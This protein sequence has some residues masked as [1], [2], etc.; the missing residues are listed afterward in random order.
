MRI[1]HYIPSIDRS[2]GGTSA[3]MQLLC[4]SLGRMAELH[5]ATHE[6]RE[7]LP[8]PGARVHYINRSLFGGMKRDWTALLDEVRPD[9]VH[10]NG[11]WLPQCAAAQRWAV[12]RGARV[13]L[14][15]HGMLE[16]WIM[17][18]HRYTRKLPALWLYQARAVRE[19]AVVVATSA[20]ERG[21]LLRLGYNRRVEVVANGV[22]AGSIAMR[23]SWRRSRKLLFLSR[24]HPKKGIELLI[25]AVAM[26][27]G[28][29]GGWTV[30]VAGEGEPDY[31][32]RLR[33][34]AVDCG[35]AARFSFVGGVY[36]EEKW[37]L[38]READAFVLPTYSENFGI[39]VAEALACGT[40]VITTTGTPW[41]EL[42]ERGC[43]WWVEA[44]A[45]AIASAIGEALCLGESELERMGRN[46]R[47]LVEE[48]YSAVAMAA[49]MLAVYEA[50]LRGG[51]GVE[52]D[53]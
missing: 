48:R 18:R 50:L 43:G 33:R 51:A 29:M 6:G 12:A 7:P 23:T 27:G 53:S 1:L 9:V 30:T 2:M 3:Y 20:A 47:R 42:R 26:L 17:A 10:V 13:A 25:E 19:A 21:N 37:R 46:G 11:C 8:M 36:G 31:V 16:P 40:P 5:V 45:Q 52:N 22:D 39:V 32:L 44:S 28:E 38:M 35:V 24:L 34:A 4:G 41:A 49:G 14:S 15:P